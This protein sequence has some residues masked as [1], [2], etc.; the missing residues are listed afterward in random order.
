MN[1]LVLLVRAF[2][3]LSL[4]FAFTF[5][6]TFTLTLTLT[7]ALP[8]YC[9]LLLLGLIQ[10]IGKRASFI[11]PLDLISDFDQISAKKGTH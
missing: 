9:Y 2:E 4:T 3:K 8:Y 5:T 11:D 10:T 1:K 6:F 7:L